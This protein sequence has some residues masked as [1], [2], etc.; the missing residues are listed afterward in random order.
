MTAA[1]AVH[2][3]ELQDLK[4]TLHQVLESKDSGRYAVFLSACNFP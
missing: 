2:E 4:N 1:S 3:T